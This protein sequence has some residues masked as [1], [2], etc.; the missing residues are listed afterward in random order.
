MSD[1][2]QIAFK[3]G[4]NDFI[5]KPVQADGLREALERCFFEA[6]DRLDTPSPTL[7]IDTPTHEIIDVK[8]NQEFL[9]FMPV[10]T[11]NNQLD[12]LFGNDEQALTKISESLKAGNRI[13]ATE[14]VHR[15]MGVCMLMGFTAMVGS[16]EKIESALLDTA[17][18]LTPSILDQLHIDVQAT[19]LAVAEFSVTS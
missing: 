3:A 4:V 14:L 19:R 15:I 16:L 6:A 18:E 2:R 1:T 9:N 5:T 13:E 12:E 11:S 10:E 8:A 17:N 7:L